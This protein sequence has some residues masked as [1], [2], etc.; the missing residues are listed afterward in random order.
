MM[1]SN[2]LQP[3]P[4]TK[5]TDFFPYIRKI[6]LMS[7]NS[8]VLSGED[9]IALI[10]PGALDDQFDFLSKIIITLQEK[11]LRPVVIYLT[12]THLDHCFQLKRCRDNRELGN[13]LVAVQDRGAKAL[14]AQD[15]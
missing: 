11:K 10:D 7:S 13:I 14:E 8:Y 1:E 4:G 2:V 3:V 5:G 6:D 9:Q 15:A 12:H